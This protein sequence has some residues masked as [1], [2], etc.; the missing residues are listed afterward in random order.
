MVNNDIPTASEI[1]FDRLDTRFIKGKKYIVLL[2]CGAFSPLTNMHLRILED[3]KNSLENNGYQVM[4][5]FMSPVHPDYKKKTLAPSHHR[6]NMVALALLSSTWV[7]SSNWEI[8][9]KCWTPT[10]KVLELFFRHINNE[11]Y[12]GEHPIIEVRLLC[13]SDLICT[14]D[15][16]TWSQIDQETILEKYG[17]VCVARENYNALYQ[18]E[19]NR[20]L[21]KYISQIYLVTPSVCIAISST[22]I[23]KLLS[24]KMSIRYLVPD[25][26]EKYIYDNRLNELSEWK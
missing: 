3:A 2:E 15:S 12:K 26:V 10:V 4:G 7:N 11:I 20:I 13:G 5:G 19:K 9:Q 21:K 8:N 1:P 16:P 6:Y 25:T 24:D 23:R 14:F 22:L 17:L 18:I